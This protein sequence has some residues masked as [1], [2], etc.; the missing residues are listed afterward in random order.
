[1]EK[2]TD[3]FAHVQT[4]CTRPLLEG[5]GGGPGNEATYGSDKSEWMGVTNLFSHD[6]LSLV[7]FSMRRYLCQ[8]GARKFAC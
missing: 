3:Y 6:F 5:G 2:T 1:M 8:N 4:V 7:L